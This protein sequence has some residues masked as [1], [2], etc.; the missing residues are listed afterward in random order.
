MTHLTL[1]EVVDR[2]NQ[3]YFSV[4]DQRPKYDHAPTQKHRPEFYIPRITRC[5]ARFIFSTGPVQ[6]RG[7]V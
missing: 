6:L 3:I 4:E 5:L 1:Q 2:I 7:R